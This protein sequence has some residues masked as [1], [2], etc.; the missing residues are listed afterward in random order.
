MG[1][2]RDREGAGGCGVRSRA[3]AVCDSVRAGS[4]KGQAAHGGVGEC[5]ERNGNAGVWRD[6][7]ERWWC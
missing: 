2:G 7:D 5:E 4:R 3:V 6:G 1:G